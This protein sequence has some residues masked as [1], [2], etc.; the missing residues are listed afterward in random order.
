METTLDIKSLNKKGHKDRIKI[1]RMFFLVG[2][3][4]KPSFALLDG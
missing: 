2:L 1:I 3:I 4:M